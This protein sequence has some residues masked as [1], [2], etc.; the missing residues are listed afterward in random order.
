MVT[1]LIFGLTPLYFVILAAAVLSLGFSLAYKIFSDQATMRELKKDLKK[2]RLQ[3][4][5]LKDKPDKIKE[6]T[7]KSMSTNMKYMKK[8]MRPMLITMVPVIFIFKWLKG[9]L[10]GIIILPLTF[11]PGHLGW[12]GAYIIFSIFFTTLFRKV[13]KVA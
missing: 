12:F 4:R 10:G 5:E 2:Y 1:G 8:S 3:M 6:L 13:L 9:L 7:Q 11:W